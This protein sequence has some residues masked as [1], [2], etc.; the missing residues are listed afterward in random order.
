MTTETAPLSQDTQRALQA[1]GISPA[2]MVIG[3]VGV[4]NDGVTVLSVGDA[5]THRF[6]AIYSAFGTT[7]QMML[8]TGPGAR[9][10]PFGG[11]AK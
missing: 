5:K 11:N 2:H 6:D 7:S 4:G 9:Y 8:A 3:S 1:A 10:A